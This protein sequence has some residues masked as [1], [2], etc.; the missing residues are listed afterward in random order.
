MDGYDGGSSI[1]GNIIEPQV[2]AI[3]DV[4]TPKFWSN[5]PVL[6][7]VQLEAQFR[8]H[9]ITS[10]N[11][12]FYKAMSALDMHALSAVAHIVQDP[13][14]VDKYDAIKKALIGRYTESE[15]KRIRKLLQ[16]KKLDE[17]KPTD[18]LREMREQTGAKFNDNLLKAI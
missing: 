4:N 15:E 10:D 17:R 6:W 7:F 3:K 18:L 14:D 16:G 11:S 13:S 8:M 5:R 12:K 2:D 1:F 9:V